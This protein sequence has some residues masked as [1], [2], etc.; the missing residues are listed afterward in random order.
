MTPGSEN[1][2]TLTHV[3]DDREDALRLQSSI[4]FLPVGE[5]RSYESITQTGDSPLAKSLFGIEGVKSVSLEGVFITLI[6]DESQD[7]Q[8]LVDSIQKAILKFFNAGGTPVTTSTES[9][10]KFS[11]GFK[12]VTSRPREEQIRLVKDMLDNEVNPAVSSHGGFFT[13]IDIKDDTVFVEMGGGCQGC[14]MASS[15]LRQGV[16]QRLKEVLPEM[17]AL[18]D[19]TDHHSGQN[20]Y[21]QQG[22]K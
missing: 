9:K 5:T 4:G 11:F 13:L 16:E 18:V 22:K 8:P 3:W 2:I 20:P 19:T 6:L 21:Y 12:Q 14:G 1:S 17:V 7:W 10:K 15:T